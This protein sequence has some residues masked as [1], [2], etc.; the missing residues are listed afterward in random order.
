M[1]TTTTTTTGRDK[2]TAPFILYLFWFLYQHPLTNSL[3]N[4]KLIDSNLKPGV[5]ELLRQQQEQQ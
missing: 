1:T 4:P 2:Q 5:K 3:I